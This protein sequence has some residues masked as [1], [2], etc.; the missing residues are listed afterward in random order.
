MT[1]RPKLCP[2]KNCK[3]VWNKLDDE[4]WIKGGSGA[5]VGILKDPVKFVYKEIVHVNDYCWCE[6]TPLKG[7]VK[8]MK[9]FDDAW[10]DFLMLTT[11]MDKLRPRYCKECGFISRKEDSIV[12]KLDEGDYCQKCMVRLGKVE[13]LPDEKRYAPV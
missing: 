13:W 10:G 4:W 2:E 5:C 6:F 12:Y 9:N 7:V 11:I 1:K 8:F 3:P